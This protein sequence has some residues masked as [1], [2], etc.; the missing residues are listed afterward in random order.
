MVVFTDT[1]LL[2]GIL[3]S[4]FFFL[5]PVGLGMGQSWSPGE[6]LARVRECDLVV[7]LLV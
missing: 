2:L 7:V 5:L 1:K 6:R 3:W 4:I